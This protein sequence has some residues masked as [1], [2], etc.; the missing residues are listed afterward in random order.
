MK[1]FHH[2][3]REMQKENDD[4]LS[5]IAKK[6]RECEVKLEEKVVNC[7]NRYFRLSQSRFEGKNHSIYINH[8]STSV[9]AGLKA[10]TLA[11]ILTTLRVRIDFAILNTLEADHRVYN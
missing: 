3:I 1:E 8:T 5:K 9:R 11:I 4:L 6:E 7:L 10:N 2:K